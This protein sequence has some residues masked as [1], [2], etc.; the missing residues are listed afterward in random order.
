MNVYCGVFIPHRYRL[1]RF[2]V[3]MTQ[4]NY[5]NFEMSRPMKFPGEWVFPGGCFEEE[6][7]DLKNT[8]IREFIEETGYKGEIL[9]VN[10]L[11][12]KIISLDERKY[13][14]RIFTGEIE[15]YNF[16]EFSE[17]DEVI[18]IKWNTPFRWL[19]IIN[20]KEFLEEKLK[21]LKFYGIMNQQ[22]PRASIETLEELVIY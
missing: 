21:N 10:Y 18:D 8:A 6:D 16:G 20:S 19:E 9:S 4:R 5:W 12:E 11:K 3:L 2:E 7:L 13:F 14:V 22:L 17:K 15:K 1:G